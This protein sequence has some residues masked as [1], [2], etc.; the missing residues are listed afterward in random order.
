[1]DGGGGKVHVEGESD[2]GGERVGGIREG[3]GI[4]GCHF[5]GFRVCFCTSVGVK[6]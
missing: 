2:V 1:M 5:G 3:V 4:N 6:E